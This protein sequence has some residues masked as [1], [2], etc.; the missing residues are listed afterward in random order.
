[1]LDKLAKRVAPTSVKQHRAA[2]EAEREQREQT[3]RDEQDARLQEQREKLAAGEAIRCE[4]CLRMIESAADVAEKEGSL[5]H[6]G[7]CEQQ[8]GSADDR[9]EAEGENGEEAFDEAA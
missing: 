2:Q 4:C 7:E 6:A 3:W 1:M 9:T 5:V 8:W